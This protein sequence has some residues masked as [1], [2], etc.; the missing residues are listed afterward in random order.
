[1]TSALRHVQTSLRAG[2]RV[3]TCLRACNKTTLSPF[4]L[5]RLVP[6]QTRAKGTKST[7]DLVPGSQ[8]P[9]TDEAAREEYKK[10]EEKMIAAVEW[11]RKECAAVETRAS[12]RVTPHLLAPVRVKLPD[13]DQSFRLEE[14]ATV[15]VKDG[16]MLLVT[17][18]DEGSLKHVETAIYEAKL[19]GIIPQKYDNRTLRIP[20]P[21][22]TVEARTAL[23]TATLRQAEDSKVQIRKHHQA[24]LKRGKYAK[25]SIELEE[26]QKLTDRN[27]G[28][29][30][31]RISQLKKATGAGKK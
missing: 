25:H 22:P 10:C 16:S 29:I 14:V 23:V 8:Q 12:G 4:L 24:S 2:F 15:G 20:V 28:E 9:I 18:F 5:H 13:S 27:V 1:M 26:F 3:S 11:F 30:D 17:V 19:A 21:K 31:A 6:T 7:A